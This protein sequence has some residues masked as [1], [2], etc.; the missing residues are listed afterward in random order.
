MLMSSGPKRDP[1]NTLT[2]SSVSVPL[3][4]KVSHEGKSNSNYSNN[5]I[6]HNNAISYALDMVKTEAAR[7]DGR[8]IDDFS[9][10][11]KGECIYLENFMC[12][13]S[14]LTMFDSLKEELVA[15]SGESLDR[16]GLMDWSKHQVYENPESISTVFRG[17]IAALAEYFDIDV[18]A[19]R[20]NYYKDGKQWKPYH[21]DSHAYGGKAL[22]EDFTVGVSL[23]ATRSLSFLHEPSRYSFA[24]PQKNGDVFA[25][26]TE[27]NKKFMHGVPRAT[28]NI[29][30]RFSIIA[31]GRRR[32]INDRNGGR[33]DIYKQ[34]GDIGAPTTYDEA[35]SAAH[36]LVSGHV[37]RGVSGIVDKSGGEVNNMEK[38]T[39]ECILNNKDANM[40]G[41]SK[42]KKPKMRLQ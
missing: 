40:T 28:D 25:F 29:G 16:N 18:Y 14:D 37:V 22:R 35:I 27:V 39:T 20:L 12:K 7:V 33:V 42:A 2:T 4:S 6:S 10:I 32:T 3:Q 8:L 11:I 31:W 19:T 15:H 21:H 36:Q 23:G 1:S 9:A 38:T 41:A 17:I 5:Y 34:L 26:T 13:T 30:D 24:F